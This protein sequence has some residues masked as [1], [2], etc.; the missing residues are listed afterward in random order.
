ML[1]TEIT[2]LRHFLQNDPTS[3]REATEAINLAAQRAAEIAQQYFDNIEGMPDQVRGE[4]N[5]LQQLIEHMVDVADFIL[6]RQRMNLCERMLQPVME[7][8]LLG[9]SAITGH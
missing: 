3:V 5:M 4:L 2:R 9:T 7:Y 1:H 8:S 6:T